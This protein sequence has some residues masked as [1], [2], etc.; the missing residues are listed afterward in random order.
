MSVE[1]RLEDVQRVAEDLSLEGMREK[2]GYIVCMPWCAPAH[3]LSVRKHCFA[4]P[5]T[6]SQITL[7]QHVITVARRAT[8]SSP[9]AATLSRV[10]RGIEAWQIGLRRH[11]TL[12]YHECTCMRETLE[13]RRMSS[14][15]SLF[16]SA[17]C[18]RVVCVIT[19]GNVVYSKDCIFI[20]VNV[21]PKRKTA[22][23]E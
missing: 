15:H 22:R 16:P 4:P 7:T 23:N 5:Q 20:R 11:F 14:S 12:Y 1:T 3:C 18:L 2:R 8:R 21:L 10:L 6:P 9:S 13:P 17:C 19:F